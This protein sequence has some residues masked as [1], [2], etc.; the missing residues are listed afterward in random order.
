MLLRILLA[1]GCFVL[2]V[3]AEWHDTGPW[4]GA[5]EAIRVSPQIPG[6][7]IAATRNGLLYLSDNSG[8]SWKPL[9]FPGEL[10]GTLHAL[11]ADTRGAWYAGM[12][13]E[14]EWSSGLY[15]STNAGRSWTLLPGLKGKA[16]WSLAIWPANPDVIAAGAADGVYL[17]RDAGESWSRISPQSNRELRPVVSLAF[18]PGNSK[19]LYAGTTH[20][21]WR[22]INGG[23]TWESIHDGMHDDS[24]VFSIRVDPRNPERVFASACSGVY[25]S[26]NGGVS[27]TRLPTPE[28]AFRTYLVSL[29]PHNARIL[30]AGTSAGLVRSVNDGA[31]WERVSPA[32]VKSIAFDPYRDG[33][34]LFASTSGVLASTNGGHTVERSDLGFSNRSFTTLA[35]AGGVLYAA[36]VYEPGTGGLWRSDGPGLAWRPVEGQGIGGNIL[37]LAVSPDQVDTVFAAGYRGLWKSE[38]G[39]RSWMEIPEPSAAG[40][41]ATLLALPSGGLLAGADTG[42]YRIS[43][44]GAWEPIPLSPAANRVEF[45]QRSGEKAIAAITSE[46]AFVAGDAEGDWKACGPLPERAA[47][48]GLA[49]DPGGDGAALAATSKG[50][51][52]SSDGCSSWSP[53]RGGLDGG[54]VS[55]VLFHPTEPGVVFASQDG[56]LVLSTDSGVHWQP[57]DVGG[58]HRF[59]PST[60]LIL[61]AAPERLF[62]LLPRRGVLFCGIGPD[63]ASAHGSSGR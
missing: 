15:K 22:T 19:V 40:R 8:A 54:T 36:S 2:S 9:P 3:H 6:L 63:V 4:G 10:T 26:T 41:I 25:K 45:L 34:V 18:H 47:W 49:V 37:V 43:E 31:T 5:A 11:E 56:G 53:V 13:G 60:L 59:W 58:R 12:E 38:D 46:G 7:A 39:G 17:S 30:F 33:R 20:L 23:T 29:D 62:A 14:N 16:I 52:R 51:F 32:A 44:S 50:L 55:H 21:P 27:W 61:S 1:A 28:G 42:L 24:D 57:V 48:Y 35:G